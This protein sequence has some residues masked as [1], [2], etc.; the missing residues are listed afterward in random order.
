MDEKFRDI[1]SGKLMLTQNRKATDTETE[2]DDDDEVP[3]E[4][5]TPRK[6]DTSERDGRYVPIRRIPEED[7]LQIHTDG[8]IPGDN[9]ETNIRRSNRNSRKPNR[10]GSIPYTGN[11][12]G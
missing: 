3:E 8:K 12:L 10:Y 2:E 1:L 6:Y 11:L 5:G 4:T 9:L 7:T